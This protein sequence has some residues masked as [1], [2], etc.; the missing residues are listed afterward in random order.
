[1]CINIGPRNA[2]AA[3]NL[4][5]YLTGL[6]E[7]ACAGCLFGCGLT[8]MLTLIEGAQTW[9][10][11]LATRPDPERFAHVLKTFADAREALHRR[12]HQ[13]GIKH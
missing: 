6:R 8:Y 13:H 2:V 12:L 5:A 10:E 3:E 9:V 7:N 1:M 11:Q 4:C